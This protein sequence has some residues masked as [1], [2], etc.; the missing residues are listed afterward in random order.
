[1]S[2]PALQAIFLA[3]WPTMTIVAQNWTHIGWCT[4][5]L[6]CAS[7]AHQHQH[8]RLS[9]GGM[10]NLGGIESDDGLPWPML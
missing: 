9:F 4:V 1:M 5:C 7:Q 2:S 3:E 6:T 8:H 10:V